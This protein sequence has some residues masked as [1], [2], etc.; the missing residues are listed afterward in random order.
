M[1]HF[2]IHFLFTFKRGFR[3]PGCKVLRGQP[4]NEVDKVAQCHFHNKPP[5]PLF[6]TRG[7]PRRVSL[8]WPPAKPR[9]WPPAPGLGLESAGA[10]AALAA[11]G[12]APVRHSVLRRGGSQGRGPV[13]RRPRRSPARPARSSVPSRPPLGAS[14]GARSCGVCTRVPREASQPG[15]PPPQRRWTLPDGPSNRHPSPRGAAS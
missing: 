13:A 14:E 11:S 6:P 12:P 10:R 5:E 1:T 7:G 2:F 4:T 3:T 9:R 8:R 15:R